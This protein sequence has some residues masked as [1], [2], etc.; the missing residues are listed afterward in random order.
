MLH[1]LAA[2]GKN[3]RNVADERILY[4]ITIRFLH[5][6]A[7]GADQSSLKKRFAAAMRREDRGLT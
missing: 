5:N 4:P 7:N 6:H 1:V 2:A 3:I